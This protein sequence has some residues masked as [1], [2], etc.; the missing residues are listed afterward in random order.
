MKIPIIVV[1]AAIAVTATSAWAQGVDI[2]AAN[3]A[4]EVTVSEKI[5]VQPDIA[6]IIFGLN[7]FGPT[8]DAAYQDNL[9]TADIVIKALLDAGVK[10]ESIETHALSLDAQDPDEMKKLTPD[11]QK[12][13]RYAAHQ[14]WT[15]TTAADNAQKVV[16]IAMHAGANRIEDVVWDVSDPAA[17]NSRA[18]TAALEKA[19]QNAQQIANGLGGKLGRVI[20]ASNSQVEITYVSKRGSNTEERVQFVAS[21]WMRR[22]T[23]Q[24]FP[25]KIEREA[26]VHAV[27][28]LE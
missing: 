11:A 14:S 5:Q 12:E 6:R 16:D 24:L 15:V 25:Q 7:S 20:Y 1:L 21:F 19:R 22:S 18:L 2:S 17:L 9:R 28:A 23:L 10:R 4:I 13:K 26:T 8:H 27:F 3:K